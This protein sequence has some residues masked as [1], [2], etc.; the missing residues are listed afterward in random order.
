MNGSRDRRSPSLRGVLLKEGCLLGCSGRVGKILRLEEL[1]V[2]VQEE[3][4]NRVGIGC[5]IGND[6]ELS[7]VKGLNVSCHSAWAYKL[8]RTLAHE[9]AW[10]HATLH[11]LPKG[12]FNGIHIV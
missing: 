2:I 1:K 7:H 11:C 10:V 5:I 8:V 9:G 4:T 6:E 12:V 3:L